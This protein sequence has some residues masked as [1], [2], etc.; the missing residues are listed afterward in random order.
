MKVRRGFVPVQIRRDDQGLRAD[1]VPHPRQRLSR[2]VEFTSV[3]PLI[4][5]V[6]RRTRDEDVQA[7]M[8]RPTAT[9]RAVPFDR[10]TSR[11]HPLTLKVEDRPSSMGG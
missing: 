4:R 10:L 5:T 1:G 8:R 11:R 9:G 6:G 3:A 7:F 2:P